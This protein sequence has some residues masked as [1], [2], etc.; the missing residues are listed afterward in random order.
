M[1]EYQIIFAH[2]DR[3]REYV[4]EFINTLDDD[5]FGHTTRL[6][7]LL[8]QHGRGLGSKYIKRIRNSIYELRV[9]GKIHIRILFTFNNQEIILL[10][11]FK[12]KSNRIPPQEIETARER[13]KRY[14]LTS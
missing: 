12:K 1:D 5:T 9:L 14:L 4:T 2:S 6:I 10:H 11:A 7:E 3:G 13:F 8:S